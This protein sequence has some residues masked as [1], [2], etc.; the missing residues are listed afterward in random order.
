MWRFAKVLSV[1]LVVVLMGMAI[2]PAAAQDEPPA[3]PG[4]GGII[5]EASTSEPGTFNPLYCT[6]TS[7]FDDAISLFSPNVVGVDPATATFAKDGFLGAL[8][9]DWEITEGGTV[10]IFTLRED[11]FWTDG[12][13]VTANDMV[14]TFNTTIDP[15]TA[16]PNAYVAD[17]IE[18]MEA[19]DDYTL[20]VT[21]TSD[22]CNNIRYVDYPDYMPAHVFEGVP[23]AELEEHP[24]GTQP[25]VT[26]GVFAFGEY[27]PGEQ[28]SLVAN[29]DYPASETVYGYVVPAGRI[30]KVVPDATV[31]LQQ[32]LAG[33]LSAYRSISASQQDD[34]RAAAEEGSLQAFEFKGNTWDYMAFN[35]ADPENPQPA[36]DENGER[37]DQGN[38][39]LFGDKR[40]RKAIALAIDVEAIIEGAVF[41]NG[42]RMTSVI[43]PGS[44]AYN[45][46]LP[47]IPYDVEAAKE[48]LAEAGWEP[49]EDGV[50]VATEEALYAEPGTRF[51][52]TLNTNSGNTRREAVGVIIQDQLAQIGIEVDFQAIEWNTLLDLADGQTYDAVIMGWRAGYPDDP[53]ASLT[54]IFG[55]SSDDPVAGG[56][57]DTSYYNER[58]AELADMANH[59]DGCN[60]EDMIPYL[61][62]V[63][64]IMQDEL[65]YVWLYTQNGMYG[66]ANSV[67]NFDP[68][69]AQM[70]WNIDA[71]ANLP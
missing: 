12:T 4:E 18:S 43:T 64:E 2:L 41:G 20:K 16:S 5:I 38:H 14:W 58:V 35:L 59:V 65:P 33:E 6:S 24:Y 46:D 55:P 56:S 53:V 34:V 40:V 29:Q 45:H 32:F 48:L 60:P 3:G 44:W 36:L 57:N 9:L 68:Y 50:L 23:L 63:Q 15:E 26:A 62:E 70:Y 8:A 71:W 39:P 27:R 52:F 42:E 19:I 21:F 13:P 28:F 17:Y 49:G 67:T 37:I 66:A 69:P 11:L 51:S 1:A 47:P 61:Y 25:D 22:G 54:Q 30:V 7:C 31:Q 10:Y